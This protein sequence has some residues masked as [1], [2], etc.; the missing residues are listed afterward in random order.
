MKIKVGKYTLRTEDQ[1]SMWIEEEF[2]GKDRLGRPRVYTRRI[3]GY[4]KDF[5]S[6]L[7]TFCQRR[8]CCSDAQDMKELLTDLNQIYQDMK[9]LNDT[10]VKEDFKCLERKARG[11]KKKDD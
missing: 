9:V 3:S 10:A 1:F 8:I 4:H 7:E 2:H 5:K 11:R 6:L